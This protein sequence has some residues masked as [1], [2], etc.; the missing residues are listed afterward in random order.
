MIRATLTRMN[1]MQHTGVKDIH[2]FVETHINRLI[3][4]MYEL[5]GMR[6]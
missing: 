2:S 6:R 5:D 4:Y 1:V 3:L